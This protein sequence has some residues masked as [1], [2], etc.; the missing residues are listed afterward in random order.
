MDSKKGGF[1]LECEVCMAVDA[2]TCFGRYETCS[3]TLDRC[4]TTLT[5]KSIGHGGETVSIIELKKSCGSV[6]DCTHPATLTS[7]EYRVSV[8]TKCCDKNFCNN[9][10][11]SW[12][13]P[14]PTLNGVTC[15]S[16]FA[17]NSNTCPKKTP[18]KCSGD[19]TYCVQLTASRKEGFPVTVAGCA[20]ESMQKTQ[21]RT[22]FPG[23]AVT[24]QSTG[25]SS[26]SLRGNTFLP[27]LLVLVTI[28]WTMP[29]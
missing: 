24:V 29:H 17:K 7:K 28:R 22:A 6:Y 27:P 10:T 5:E 26:T 25:S 9:S 13:R 14:N 1:A 12:E 3:S 11:I 2:V 23:S 16:C 18:L 15:Q 4:M 8:T 19:E 21:G 20:S